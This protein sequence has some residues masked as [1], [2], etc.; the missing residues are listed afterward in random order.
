MLCLKWQLK[1]FQMP[2]AET[3]R[4]VTSFCSFL[5]G[6][7]VFLSLNFLSLVCILDVSSFLDKWT[8]NIFS[9]FVAYHNF[10]GSFFKE[11]FKFW[12]RQIIIIIIIKLFMCYLRKFCQLQG[13]K[14]AKA[15]S[16]IFPLERH[17][18][19]FI[20]GT[21]FHWKLILSHDLRCK[22][23]FFPYGYSVL[24]PY[25]RKSFFS[26]WITVAILSKIVRHY[27]VA[28]V[29]FIS[30]VLCHKHTLLIIVALQ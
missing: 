17:I 30:C 7:L 16:Y 12:W 4:S 11:S 13:P 25:V 22:S 18:F 5:I 24:M 23:H 27:N 20:F 9:Q 21:V 1:Q 26:H 15:S 8:V 10:G 14:V 29:C 19:S 3:H 2:L 6:L 28:Y